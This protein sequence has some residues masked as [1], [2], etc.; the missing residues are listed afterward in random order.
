MNGTINDIVYL[1]DGKSIIGGDF[2]TV[3]NFQQGAIFKIN[4]DGTLDLTFNQNQIGFNGQ[5]TDIALRTDGKLMV[6]GYF[7]GY[8]GFTKNRFALLNTDGSADGSFQSAI[9]TGG[10]AAN[11]FEILPNGKILAGF[12]FEFY[13]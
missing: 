9:T 2:T 13:P 11:A 7:N 12:R 6:S 4:G 3:N 8:N 1:P 10:F 5:V